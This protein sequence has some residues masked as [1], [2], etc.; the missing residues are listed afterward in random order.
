VADYA[1]AAVSA[2]IGG[3]SAPEIA[4]PP[5]PASTADARDFAGTYRG[6]GRSIELVATGDRLVLRDAGDEI[7]L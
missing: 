6:E 5:D 1:L 7:V 4:A 2:A 3:A